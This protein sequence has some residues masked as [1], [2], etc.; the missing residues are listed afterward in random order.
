MAQERVGGAVSLQGSYGNPA[1][2]HH[3][4]VRVPWSDA[5]GTVKAYPEIS[6]AARS[7]FLTSSGE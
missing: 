2:A 5:S 4:N 1:P 3:L 7:R 6:L